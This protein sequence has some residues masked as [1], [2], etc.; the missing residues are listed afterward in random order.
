MA[1]NPE[2]VIVDVDAE[3]RAELKR[4]LA[5]GMVGLQ[6][7]HPRLYMP[8]F[9][10]AVTTKVVAVMEKKTRLRRAFCD[11]FAVNGY[12]SLGAMLEAEH[13]DIAAV[14]LPHDELPAAAEALL[15]PP[16]TL[17]WL[18]TWSVGIL[19]RERLRSQPATAIHK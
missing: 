16:P 19:T 10:T 7:L 5:V 6:H 9:D 14:F 2:I 11:D 1:R 12:A 18:F 15:A 13:L 17:D 3:A 8:L 4:T